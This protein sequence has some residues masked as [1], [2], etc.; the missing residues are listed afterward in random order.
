MF[1]KCVDRPHLAAAAGAMEMAPQN[2]GKIES[3]DGNGA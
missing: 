2:L 3:G 1:D